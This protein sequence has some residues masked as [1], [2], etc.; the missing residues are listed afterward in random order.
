MFGLLGRKLGHSLSPEIHAKLC[1][2]E[3]K[4]YP[5]EPENLDDFFSNKAL[6]AFNTS[7]EKIM[8]EVK[9]TINRLEGKNR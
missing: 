2:Y 9:K 7:N 4:L 3:Y 5:T 6:K 1:D 8:N